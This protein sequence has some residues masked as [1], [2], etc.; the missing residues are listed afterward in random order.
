MYLARN[1]QGPQRHL[2]IGNEESVNVWPPLKQ[3][4]QGN[5]TTLG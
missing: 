5:F 4:A 3:A 1:P 2:V